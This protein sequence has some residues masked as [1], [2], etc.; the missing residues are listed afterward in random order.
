MEDRWN[1]RDVVEL[2]QRLFNLMRKKYGGGTTLNELAILNYVFVCRVSGDAVTATGAAEFLNM[3]LTTALRALHKMLENGF[4]K[5]SR[6]PSDGRVII[7][8]MS[9]NYSSQGDKDIKSLLDWINIC[10][11]KKYS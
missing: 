2:A 8:R 1:D 6:D 5:E 7:Y 11:K 3:P 4:L 9:D 10:R